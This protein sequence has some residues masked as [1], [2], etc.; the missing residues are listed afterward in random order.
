[1]HIRLVGQNNT[2]HQAG[3]TLEVV[4]HHADAVGNAQRVTMH[5]AVELV[6]SGHAEWVG[7]HNQAPEQAKAMMA[8]STPITGV[9]KPI[10]DHD[11]LQQALKN[12]N[13]G[14]TAS[15]PVGTGVAPPKVD[16]AKLKSALQN[17][18]EDKSAPKHPWADVGKSTPKK[19][20]K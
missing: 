18:N 17:Y 7:D 13:T 20:T 8:P 19:P 9:P 6:A 15:K 14:G 5:R 10:V 12:Y 4:E 16:H 3:F 1:M 2:L 11:K